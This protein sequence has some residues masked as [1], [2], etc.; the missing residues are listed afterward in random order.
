VNTGARLYLFNCFQSVCVFLPFSVNETD[1]TVR[2]S[3]AMRALLGNGCD[4]LSY[5]TH[6]DYDS[7]SLDNDIAVLQVSKTTLA[8]GSNDIYIM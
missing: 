8:V 4:V 2:V 1:I 3:S 7:E 6:P 5:F